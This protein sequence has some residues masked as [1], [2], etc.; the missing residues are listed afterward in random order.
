PRVGGQA[1]CGARRTAAQ[2]RLSDRAAAGDTRTNGDHRYRTA[3]RAD[4]QATHPPRGRELLLLRRDV[5][6]RRRPYLSDAHAPELHTISPGRRLRAD[7]ALERT[8]HD[9]HLERRPGARLR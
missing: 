6:A 5:R 1:S 2:A 9:G 4:W 8:V 7:L 3:D